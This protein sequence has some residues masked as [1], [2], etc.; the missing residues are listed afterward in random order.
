MSHCV[1]SF[2]TTKAFYE[3]NC[4]LFHVVFLYCVF[5]LIEPEAS[6]IRLLRGHKLPVTCLVITADD[7]YV[8]S[9]SKDGSIIKCKFTLE[10]ILEGQNTVFAE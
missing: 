7:K 10:G 1:A 6:D 8:F 9:A 5:Q 3:L 4:L 2:Y